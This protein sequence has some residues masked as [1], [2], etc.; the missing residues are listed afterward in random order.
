M[1]I[2]VL[3]VTVVCLAAPAAAQHASHLPIGAK[4][5]GLLPGIGTHH[6][7]IATSS[8]EAQKYFDQGLTLV[9][10]FNHDAAVLSFRQAAE[11]DPQA[12]MPWWGIALALGPNYNLP[13][14]P[15]RE[16]AAY[17]AL[18][19]ALTR[20]ERGAPAVERAYILALAKRYAADPGDDR[21][22]LQRAY[23][24]AM[25]ALTE[26]YPD[27]LD[28]A[29]LYAESLMNLRPWQLWS[30]D[31]TP[32]D[33]TE[34]ILAV[35]ESVLRRDPDHPGANH[36][37]V[38]AVEASPRPEHALP[39][40]RR[41]ETLV[42]A[43]GHLVHMPFH[44]YYQLGR[45]SDAARV[46]DAAAA[47]DEAY[48][49]LSGDEGIYR[50]MYLSHNYHSAAM[51]RAMA[52]DFAAARRA[53]ER[54][55][56]NVAPAAAAMPMLSA[57]QTVRE[58][59]YLR[60]HRWDDVL[61]LPAPEPSSA[62]A[63][64]FW[65]F[66]RALAFAAKGQLADADRER[67]AYASGRLTVAPDFRFGFNKA[68]AIYRVADA[69]LEARLAQARGDRP[70]AIEAWRRAVAA[71]DRL[72]YGEPPDWYYPVRESLGAALLM[73]GQAPSAEAIFREDLVKNPRNGRSL[74][75]LFHALEVQGKADAAAWVRQQFEAAWMDA[76]QRL[77]IEAY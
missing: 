23:S 4:Q 22:T 44:I 5:I 74:F 24:E 20:A 65:R 67:A 32:A 33:G 7:P 63:D 52:G 68:D 58:A 2:R 53:A 41:L 59:V 62:V 21:R 51:S 61:A 37:Y 69:V 60:F 31:G 34:R 3:L 54:L 56:A 43:A 29:T 13:P 48:V 14:Q 42:P 50:F 12:A 9:F 73:D 16:K 70:G 77:R 64:S 47:S 72:A 30:A 26:A 38:H 27:D 66:A 36:Y 1:S 46:N 71:Q 75:G 40:A 6:H 17:G 39:S 45:F 10:G 28:A 8:A 11:L 49:R 55:V 57:F 35:L 76:D 19:E 25:R 18:V 15:D